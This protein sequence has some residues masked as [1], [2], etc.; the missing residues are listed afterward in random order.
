MT[1]TT[2]SPQDLIKVALSKR[3]NALANF[4]GNE[5]NALK[6]MSAV[7][8]CMQGNPKLVQCSQDSLLGA[9]MT[10]ASLNLYPGGHGG[11]C[12][13]L[14]YNTKEGMQAQFQIG[15]RGF[16]TLAYRS[17]VLRCGTEI[18]HEHDEFKQ[19]LGT[20]QS[21]HHVPHPSSRGEAIGAYAWAEVTQGNVVFK[22][23][24]EEQI[25]QIKSLAKGGDSKYS[26]WSGTNDPEK[27]MWQKTAFKQ[28]AKLL[29]TSDDLDKAVHLDN[30]SERGGYFKSETE[31]VEPSFKP[32]KT[33]E[34]KID[35]VKDKKEELRQ[36]TNE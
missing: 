10:S 3:Q 8:H 33:Q 14:P 4:L 25:M 32:E 29:P 21:L 15:Y 26:P 23:M 7:M 35:K 27:W 24:T 34:E 30:I 22:Y 28:L 6:F 9:F 31:V 17:G 16:K 11:D 12:Y 1:D 5:K 36:K 13:I 19:L 2:K 18:V 20:S